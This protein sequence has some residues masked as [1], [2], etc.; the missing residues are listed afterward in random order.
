LAETA[1]CGCCNVTSISSDG[2]W[3]IIAATTNSNRAT[4]LAAPEQVGMYAVIRIGDASDLIP[5]LDELL[6][7]YRIKQSAAVLLQNEMARRRALDQGTYKSL[8][9]RVELVRYVL[10]EHQDI[11][12]KNLLVEWR[13][14]KY[15]KKSVTLSGVLGEIDGVMKSRYFSITLKMQQGL[16]RK[17]KGNQ[18]SFG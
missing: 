8:R 18:I 10:Y 4:D 2:F 13:K 1:G 14:I 6:A 12:W 9:A 17:F 7:I 3:S 11:E 5:S 15:Y 16:S